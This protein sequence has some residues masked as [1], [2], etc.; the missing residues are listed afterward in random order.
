MAQPP[1]VEKHDGFGATPQFVIEVQPSF[2]R[3]G[4]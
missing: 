3:N 4:F 2:I 1:Q